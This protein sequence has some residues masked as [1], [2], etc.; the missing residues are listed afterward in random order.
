VRDRRES[1][2]VVAVDDQ[3]RDLV[4]LVGNDGLV[5]EGAQRQVGQRDLCGDA[6]L[7]R[8]GGD[9]GERIAAAMRCCLGE[10]RREIGEGVAPRSDRRGVH[11][12]LFIPP[13]G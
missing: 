12:R 13:V 9:A 4:G 5:K 10:Q 8:F 1:R 6:L 3:P 11:G 7:A 2:G